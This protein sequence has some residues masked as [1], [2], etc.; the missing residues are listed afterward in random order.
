[1]SLFASDD[2]FLQRAKRMSFASCMMEHYR[3]LFL[4]N[5]DGDHMVRCALTFYLYM[6][7]TEVL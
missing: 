6:S 1:M 3:F 4:D 5:S 2:E 7:Q